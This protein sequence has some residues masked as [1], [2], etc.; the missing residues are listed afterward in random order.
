MTQEFEQRRRKQQYDDTVDLPSRDGLSVEEV[1]AIIRRATELQAEDD[2]SLPT[3]D[4]EALHRVAREL[5][6]QSGNLRRAIAEAR[7]SLI[8]PEP[9]LLDR[10]LAPPSV[11]ESRVVYG[12]REVVESRLGE[13]MTRQEGLRLR[14]K[15]RDGGVWEKDPHIVTRVRMGLRLGRGSRVLRNSRKVTHR[16]QSIRDDEQAL[17][18]E[19]ETHTIK[20]V[21]AV[22]LAALGAVASTGA[23]YGIAVGAPEIAVPAAV[24]GLALTGTGVILGVRMWVNKIR[25]GLRRVL[26]GVSSQETATPPDSLDRHVKDIWRN[27][28]QFQNRRGI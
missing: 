25:E 27:W 3:L 13:W 11:T 8:R 19:A 17:A 7:T 22:G 23:A 24:A 12:D 26:D 1:E 20:S 14:R 9:S 10:I 5:G 16:I 15:D 28:R 6:I 2:F 21:G 4:E 18:L